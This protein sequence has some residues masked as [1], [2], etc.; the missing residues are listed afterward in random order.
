MSHYHILEQ[1][2]DKE[3]MVVIFHFTVPPTAE[4]AA[5]ILYTDVVLKSA[6]PLV[7]ELKNHQTDFPIE[8]AD[9]Q[10]GKIIERKITVQFSTATLTPAEKKAE[11]EDGNNYMWFG[12]NAYKTQLFNE[13]ATKWQWY[14]YDDDV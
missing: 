3:H 11:I 10:L 14:G 8:Y 9:M 1:H 7:S 2:E 12:Y 6:E 13:L 4:N 5:G